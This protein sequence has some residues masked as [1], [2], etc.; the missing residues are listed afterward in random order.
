M[1][2]AEKIPLFYYNT[3]AGLNQYQSCAFYQRAV[4]LS[5]CALYKFLRRANQQLNAKTLEK[6]LNVC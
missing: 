3:A 2:A 5:D 6:I 4:I 1:Q